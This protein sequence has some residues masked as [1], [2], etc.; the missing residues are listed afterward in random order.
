MKKIKYLNIFVLL[1]IVIS[2]LP[3]KVFGAEVIPEPTKTFYVND[4]AKVIDKETKAALAKRGKALDEK[5]G[6][7][8]VL[9]TVQSTGTMSIDD[10]AYEL[11]NNWGIGDKNKNNGMLILLSIKDDNYWV[12]QGKGI[13]KTLTND[14]ISDMLWEYLE[15][16]FAAKDYSSGAKEIYSA[17]IDKMKEISK[18]EAEKDTVKPTKD[19]KLNGA[20]VLDNA[21]ILN[22]E[23]EE[24]I[25]EK[26]LESK[27]KYNA[28][29]YVVTKEVSDGG[30]IQEDTIQVFEEIKAD[31]RDV[32]L[33][34]Y[35]EDDNYWILPGAVAQDFATQTELERIIN[36]VLEPAFAKQK[37]SSGA[38]RAGE[39]IYKLFAS[40][41]KTAEKTA[42]VTPTV[43]KEPTLPTNSSNDEEPSGLLSFIVGGLVIWF[44]IAY[45]KRKR[46]K[47]IYGVPFNPYSTKHVRLYGPNGYWGRYGPPPAGGGYWYGGRWNEGPRH[48]GNYNYV[49]DDE[50][51]R[52]SH[53]SGSSW[54]SNGGAGRPTKSSSSGSRSFGG[55]SSSSSGGAGRSFSS[56]SSSAPRSTSSSAP[57]SSSGGGGRSSSGG[58]AGRSSGG[59]AGRGSGAG[60]G[61]R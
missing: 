4:Y 54:G 19:T 9:V 6:A 50:P 55:G 33:V 24:Y 60:R 17:F 8:V 40:S 52:S 34:M 21:D 10:Y 39:E 32:L 44:L 43:N 38:I 1:V 2:I 3:L 30:D 53:N 58:G 5:Y 56:S 59:G 37:Y 51:Q 46:Y 7:Q 41:S 28:A 22:D 35:K 36:E 31:K 48:R 47:R 29:F 12:L 57:R 23:A 15:T 27:E 14:M 13:E 26:S 61:G 11:F 49:R 18:V 45:A 42:V 25:T 20:F 16:D